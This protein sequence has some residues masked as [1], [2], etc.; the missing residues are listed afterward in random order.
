MGFR[1]RMSSIL[2][3]LR[4]GYPSGVPATGYVPVLALFPRRISHDEA[5][6]ITSKLIGRKHR[7]MGRADIGVEI[8]RI[9]D[10]M[11]SLDDIEHVEH[12]LDALGWAGDEHR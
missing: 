10:E 5:E 4:A 2:T 6:M 7:S 8:S 1:A 9:T 11:P 3:F 12:R